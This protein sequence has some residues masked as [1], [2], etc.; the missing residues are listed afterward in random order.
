MDWWRRLPPSVWRHSPS[1]CILPRT[2]CC[3]GLERGGG[4][5]GTR[6]SD[7][8]SVGCGLA[9][10]AGG[11]QRKRVSVLG[12][13]GSVRHEHARPHWPQS[14]PI[15]S[16]GVDGPQ[17][18]RGAR[19]AGAPAP[20]RVAVVAEESRYGALR[21]GCRGAA[22]RWRPV[23]PPCSLLPCGRPIAS[24]QASSALPDYVRRLQP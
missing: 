8:R 15:R 7:R 11:A 10:D 1:M 14:T 2:R 20:R 17:Q 24:W 16:G 18:R 12:A 21:S 13:T 4:A 6:R 3:S 22:S 9:P 19:R 23:P 5:A